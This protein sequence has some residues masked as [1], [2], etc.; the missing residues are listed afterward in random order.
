MGGSF[1]EKKAAARVTAGLFHSNGLDL[2]RTVYWRSHTTRAKLHDLFF[3]ASKSTP[4]VAV[5]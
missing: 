4:R 1:F 3:F 2:N 5:G